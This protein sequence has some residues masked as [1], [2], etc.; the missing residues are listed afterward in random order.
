MPKDDKYF[1][2]FYIKVFEKR[3]CGKERKEEGR[4]G[5]DQEREREKKCL[6]GKSVTHFPIVTH[7]PMVTSAD[8][9][10]VMDLSLLKSHL[11]VPKA[12]KTSLHKKP[13]CYQLQS[14]M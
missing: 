11:E 10:D 1:L 2:V 7:F 13:V 8:Q 4:E 5:K 12:T 9:C 6:G 14:I 3:E